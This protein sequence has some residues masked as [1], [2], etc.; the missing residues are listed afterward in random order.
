MKHFAFCAFYI[1]TLLCMSAAFSCKGAKS[2]AVT[3]VAYSEQ[4]SSATTISEIEET[5]TTSIDVEA[6]KAKMSGFLSGYF[7]GFGVK[8]YSYVSEKKF[9]GFD[10]SG[11]NSGENI[12]S[13]VSLYFNTEECAIN[14]NI[15]DEGLRLDIKDIEEIDKSVYVLTTS[16][17]GNYGGQDDL[18]V[19]F[20]II[21]LNTISIE[22]K[23]DWE[24][25]NYS[26]VYRIQQ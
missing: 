17:S 19:K 13:E 6:V 15:A 21:D 2:S 11:E 24:A 5:T 18:K 14:F 22:Y 10:R 23:P 12:E 26:D 1:F 8:K 4:E 7:Q 3:T 20:S 25:N 16:A 9:H